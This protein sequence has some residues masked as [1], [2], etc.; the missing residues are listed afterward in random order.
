MT[1]EFAAIV[2]EQQ[3]A[4]A[5]EANEAAIAGDD[6]LVRV[7]IKIRDTI[8][9]V[10]KEYDERLAV[11]KAQK[12]EVEVEVLR[13][14]QERGATQTK[15]AAGTCFITTKEQYT[16]ADEDAFGRFVLEQQDYEFYQKRA[17]VE[18]VQKYMANNNGVMP[19]GLSVF[20]ELEIN[21]RVPRKPTAKEKADGESAS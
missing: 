18:H 5:V 6:R 21:T 8:A 19:P 16:I 12:K 2:A 3:E 15:T 7:I 20:R 11:L 4:T 1:P 9:A 13:R 17:K 10:N 14:L